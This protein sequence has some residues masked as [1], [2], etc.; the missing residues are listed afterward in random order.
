MVRREGGRGFELELSREGELVLGK[1]SLT[2]IEEKE[3][4]L[5][6]VKC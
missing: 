5:S 4:D 6:V 2:R 3:C 1:L